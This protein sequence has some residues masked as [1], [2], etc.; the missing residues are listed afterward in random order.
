MAFVVQLSD[1]L[2][3]F[4]NYKRYRRCIAMDETK[5]KIGNEW[6]YYVWAAI[7]VELAI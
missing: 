3:L 1:V 7:D 4:T 2:Q 6:W 5:I